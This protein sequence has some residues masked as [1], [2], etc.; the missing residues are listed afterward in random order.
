MST[1]REELGN[2]LRNGF[3]SA[4]STYSNFADWYD[5]LPYGGTSFGDEIADFAYRNL[6]NREPPP[7]PPPPFTGGQCPKRYNVAVTTIHDGSTTPGVQPVT[8]GPH[9]RQVWG[10]ISGFRIS[11]QGTTSKLL[12]DCQGS[13]A[14]P[15][16]STAVEFTSVGYNGTNTLGIQSYSINY[17][18]P[19]D[20][21]PDN[22]GDPPPIIPPPTPNYNTDNDT[23]TYNDNS[24]NSVDVDISYTFGSPVININGDLTVPVRVNVEGTDISIGGSFSVNNPEFN[25]NF[26]DT[27]YSP[28][29]SSNGSDYDSEEDTPEPPPDV[30]N[31]I[32][33]TDPTEPD[34]ETRRTIRGAI[35]TVTEFGNSQG[36]LFQEDNPDIAIPNFG[37][38]SFFCQ[39][40]SRGA[41]TIDV[42]V[43]NRR[44]LIECPWSGG[45]IDVA[46]TPRAGVSWQISEVYAVEENVVSFEV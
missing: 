9:G 39:I 14:F 34:P 24:N 36:I 45:A 7:L 25:F 42:P 46:G 16:G 12:C 22:C 2:T 38:I 28:S 27:N 21:T 40:G 13:G 41:W 8:T 32:P 43:K 26:G 23:V 20:G 6:C 3:C 5:R 44:C 1:F 15:S 18:T 19:T 4:L 29:D 11:N 30:P 31:P 35:V 17:I 10:P 33:P 37:Y